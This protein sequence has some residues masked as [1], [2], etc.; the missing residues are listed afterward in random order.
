M[1]SKSKIAAIALT[2]TLAF[3]STAQAESVTL[4][5]YVRRMVNQAMEVEQQ[6]ITKNLNPA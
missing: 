6:E 1:F 2:S 5:K 3:A 4:E